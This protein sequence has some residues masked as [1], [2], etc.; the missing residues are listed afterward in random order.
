M[1]LFVLLF[2]ISDLS[3]AASSHWTGKLSL[4][5][6]S[7]RFQPCYEREVYEL[8]GSEEIIGEIEKVFQ[9]LRQE[10]ERRPF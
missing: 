5:G 9:T 4:E 1:K 3:Q 6:G 8:S 10:K 7:Y 2:L